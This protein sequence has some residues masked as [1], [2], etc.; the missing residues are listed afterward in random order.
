MTQPRYT[1]NWKPVLV[2][3][4]LSP[5]IGELLSGSSPP[6]QFFNPLFF[7]LLVGLYGCGALLVRE[8][9]ARWQLNSAGLLLL[10]AAYGIIE[11]G[12]TCKSFFNPYWTDTGF[13][14]VYGRAAGVNWVWTFGLT[15][16][17]MVVSVT[18]PIFLTEAV[19]SGRAKDPWL[20]RRGWAFA[21]TALALVMILGFVGFDNPQFH[22]IEIKD[23]QGLARDLAR[24]ANPVASFISDSLKPK[25][26]EL[27]QQPFKEGD[28]SPELRHAL[29]DELNRVL[30]RPDLYT[31]ARFAG[32]ALTDDS[33]R[34]ATNLPHGDKLVQFN[35]SLLEDAFPG[36]QATRPVYPFR[37][38]WWLTLGSIAA[39][40]GLVL[41]ALRQ[42]N[43]AQPAGTLRRPWLTGLGFTAA[44]VLFGFVLPSLVEHG[45]PIPAAADC[46]IWC[47][48]ALLLGRALRK[49]DAAPDRLWRRGLL[50]IGVITP[51]VLFAVILGVFVGMIG[52]KSFSG[53]PVVAVAFGTGIFTLALKW[54]RP[55]QP[56]PAQLGAPA[57]LPAAS[58]PVKDEVNR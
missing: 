2:L 47:G 5:A 14:S 9:V 16:Y 31:P 11:E 25:T 41:L 48:I 40:A 50:A 36:S 24:P 15:V 46:A 37:P 34:Q 3:L 21:G 33:S 29:Q 19:F 38:A 27:L 52:A 13:L 57:R 1:G 45:L 6:Q 51:W 7:V 53:M 30:P 12:L 55:L 20:E 8:T 58:T 44:F 54:R 18:V 23:P 49:T 39:V 22:L 28:G 43:T 26:R 4:V 32:I 17:H 10:G 35:R 42:R 56:E